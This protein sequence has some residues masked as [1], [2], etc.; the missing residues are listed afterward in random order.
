MDLKK[1]HDKLLFIPLGGSGEFGL[2]L[3]LYHYKGS[4]VMLDC[5][6]GFADGNTM[7]GI[8]MLVPDISFIIDNKI[9]IDAMVVTHA[10]EDHL[11]AVC[12]LWPAL[13]CDVYTTKFTAEL[14]RAKLKSFA[15]ERHV[16]IIEISS[17][18]NTFK[19][20]PFGFEMIGLTHSVPEMNAAVIRTN[21]GNI[22]HSGD[23]KLDPDPVIGTV[24][25]DR[26][27][28]E[29]SEKEG[30]LGFVS[31][32][33]KIFSEGWSRSEGQLE[34]P[35][36]EI[37]K[38]AKHLVAITTFASNVARIKTISNIA[39][40]TGR[41]IAV[42]GTSMHR[43]IG[44]AKKCG[45]LDGVE[46][47]DIKDVD[48]YDRNKLIL[49]CTGC[50]GEP[51]ASIAKL[52]N[53][54]FRF[55]K[56][57]SGD[58]VLFSSSIIPGNEKKIFPV[59]N[60]FVSMG[61]EVVTDIDHEVHASGHPN[62]D[63]LKYMYEI[64]R[65]KISLPVHGEL[66]HLK[67]HGEFAKDVCGIE[68]VFIPQNGDVIEITNDNAKKIG[69]VETGYLGIDGLVLRKKDSPVMIMRRKLKQSG[70]I[71]CSFVLNQNGKLIANPRICTP[72]CLD[73]VNEKRII[74]EIEKRVISILDTIS[75][76]MSKKSKSSLDAFVQNVVA[77]M[78]SMIRNMVRTSVETEP[79]IEI[80]Y[81]II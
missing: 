63:E 54:T 25:N 2:N 71:I 12:Y 21:V 60:K 35:L 20:G 34:S 36:T 47:L 30:V 15:F 18:K 80:T 42:S 67:K 4:W 14:L 17:R 77:E 26:R 9:N 41:K 70:I 39:T 32:S 31:D 72:G 43:I 33:T 45:Y 10:H 59:L 48:K 28:K 49:L 13:K 24:S 75:L 76:K 74:L 6:A 55:C 40:A 56:I 8:D 78:K 81:D 27:L 7:P 29:I 66:L 22:V 1:V 73:V 3:N 62:K 11:G 58:M 69:S 44:A 37:V 16:K 57:R 65:P 38:K 79:H 46:F 23:W 61:I 51:L 50:Q 19:I 64:L 53:N 5:G 68:K 52:A